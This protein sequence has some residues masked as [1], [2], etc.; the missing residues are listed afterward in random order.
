MI[1]FVA[2]MKF[3]VSKIRTSV[4]LALELC[5][6][7]K[8]NIL[9]I[10]S[11]PAGISS[12]YLNHYKSTKDLENLYIEKI[13]DDELPARLSCLSDRY[14]TVLVDIGLGD[15]LRNGLAHCNRLYVPLNSEKQSLWLMWVSSG[16]DKHLEMSLDRPDDFKAETFFVDDC[17]CNDFLQ[18]IKDSVSESQNLDF[19]NDFY[20]N[21]KPVQS[22][23]LCDSDAEFKLMTNE[24][25]AKQFEIA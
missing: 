18:S 4:S 21:E 20:F 3:G 14:D 2:G 9:F 22:L 19:I 6:E 5:Q 1:Y 8:D 10:D 13:N 12:D 7:R 25:R 11:D 23:M 17:K 24:I 16:V 15:G